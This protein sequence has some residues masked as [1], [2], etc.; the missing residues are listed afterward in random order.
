MHT[1]LV[2]AH[3]T[4]GVVATILVIVA[5]LTRKGERLHKAA[6]RGFAL[7]MATAA[8]SGF[9]L[10]L[11]D[12]TTLHRYER[13]IAALLVGL[14]AMVGAATWRGWRAATGHSARVALDRVVGAA[15]GCVALGVL[16]GAF[17]LQSWLLGGLATLM[18]GALLRDQFGPRPAS[19][20]D[21]HLASNAM[22][23]TGGLTGFLILRGAALWVPLLIAVAALSVL[24]A[25]SKFLAAS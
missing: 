25:R 19:H 7:A 2:V 10:P 6:G 11:W 13:P 21:E 5:L 16:A 18:C 9:I 23:I 12:L 15:V 17:M 14:S 22:A 1:Y 8:I 3:A 24:T 20:I 4:A